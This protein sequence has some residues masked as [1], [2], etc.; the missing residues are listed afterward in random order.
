MAVKRRTRKR[1]WWREL[2]H[3][4]EGAALVEFALVAPLLFISVAGVIEIGMVM[5]VNS[6]IEGAVRYAARAGITG[7]TPAGVTRS[8]LIVQTIVNDTVGLIQPQ[9]IT[10]TTLVYSSFTSVGQ[11]EAYTDAN[12]NGKY[13]AGEAFTDTN[14]NGQWDADMGK[15]GLGGPGDVV[16]YTANVNWH[17]MTHLLDSVM[18][19]NGI[20]KLSA[21]TAVRNEPWGTNGPAS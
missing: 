12:G 16:L 3:R 17:L 21:S 11:P 13:D 7:Q 8:D 6:L 15:A 14:G 20:M 10:I 2:W 18:G 1:G 4:R 5:F 9:D 19:K